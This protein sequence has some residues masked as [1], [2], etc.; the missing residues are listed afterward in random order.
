MNKKALIFLALLV[1]LSF[2][3]G[4]ITRLKKEENKFTQIILV[5]R[6]EVKVEIAKTE[7]E[8]EQGLS[9]RPSLCP[10][11]GLLFVYDQKGIYPFWM[12]KMHFDIDIIWINGNR[13]A[14]I[15]YSAPKPPKEELESPKEIFRSQMPIDKVLEVNSGWARK[16]GV[17]VGDE[18]AEVKDISRF[19]RE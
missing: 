6:R 12:R 9:D 10:D 7:A 19:P 5:G 14:E 2:F 1:P 16:N 8:K 3:L 13:V 18:V 17:K 4:F 11:C 15:T